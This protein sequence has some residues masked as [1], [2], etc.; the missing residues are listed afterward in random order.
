[1]KHDHVDSDFGPVPG[2]D[3]GQIFASRR[4]LFDAGVHRQLQA[5]ISGRKEHGAQSIVVSGGYEDDEDYG[6][7]IIY[8]G[9][10]GRDAATGQQVKDQ[11]LTRGNAALVT[12]LSTGWPVRVVRSLTEHR[13]KAVDGYRYDGLFRVEDYWSE[14]GRSG[15]LVWRYRLAQL[16][17]GEKPDRAPH[18]PAGRTTL[19]RVEVKVQR[20]VRST[21]VADFVKRVHDFTCQVCGLRLPT[22][23]GAYAEAAHIQ[24]LGKPHNGPDIPANVLCLCPNHHTLFDFGMLSIDDDLSVIDLATGRSLGRL[25]LHDAHEIDPKY[26]AYHR[27]HHSRGWVHAPVPAPGPGSTR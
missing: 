5:G 25:T 9:Q 21:S 11:E 20:I 16:E 7:V 23:T 15:F 1:M 24:G 12:S 14:L 13:R 18:R 22:P 2:V 26:L 3:L 6:N 19:T 8:T 10:G 4:L 17:E 27:A